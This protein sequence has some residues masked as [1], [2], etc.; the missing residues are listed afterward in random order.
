MNFYKK[1][2]S[3]FTN[4]NTQQYYTLL[5]SS[6]TEIMSITFANLPIW[7]IPQKTEYSYSIIGNIIIQDWHI[8]M[9]FLCNFIS[10]LS[11]LL[12][13]VIEIYREIWLI[14]HFDYSK[15]YNTINLNKY[16][17]D[18]PDLFTFLHQINKIYFYSYNFIKWLLLLN[19]G[20]SCSLLLKYNYGGYKMITN[21]ITNFSICVYKIN[22]GL[23]VSTESLK[24]GIGYSY[25]NIQQLSFNRIDPKIKKHI[26]HSSHSTNDSPNDGFGSL[27]A[28]LNASINGF[29]SFNNFIIDELNDEKNNEKLNIQLEEVIQDTNI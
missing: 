24:K 17:N 13:Y 9:I 19:I 16:K 15:K 8:I 10:W 29:P 6:L 4:Q 14:R 25:F 1:I 23:H 3:Y 11:F 2:K 20:V 26:S 27:N 5:F 7:F 22:T 21:L 12:L 28:S 18:Y